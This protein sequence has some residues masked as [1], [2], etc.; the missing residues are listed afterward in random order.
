[1]TRARGLGA[2]QTSFTLYRPFTAFGFAVHVMR[3]TSGRI[4]DVVP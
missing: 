1:M 3:R 4:Q 2:P